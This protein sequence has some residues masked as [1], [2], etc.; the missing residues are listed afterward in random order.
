[1][2]A[3]RCPHVNPEGHQS[4]RLNGHLHHVS[5]PCIP[6][7]LHERWYLPLDT[8]AATQP[9]ESAWPWVS[10]SPY[11]GTNRFPAPVW[12][13]YNLNKI[14]ICILLYIC[15]HSFTQV[16]LLGLP[17]CVRLRV[18]ILSTPLNRSESWGTEGGRLATLSQQVDR[19]QIRIYCRLPAPHAAVPVTQRT[20]L[21]HAC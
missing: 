1:M 13:N 21:G 12:W 14:D 11:P 9:V 10:G 17:H 18:Q 7:P 16:I 6:S 2:W 8:S 3:L 20:E 4:W 5:E 19:S 15:Q